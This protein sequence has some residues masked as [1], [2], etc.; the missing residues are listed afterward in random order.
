MIEDFKSSKFALE[1]FGKK[2]GKK[3]DYLGSPA[4]SAYMY[5]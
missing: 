1:K 2:F 4:P 5:M 3:F